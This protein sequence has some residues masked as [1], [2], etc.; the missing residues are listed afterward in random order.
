MIV[1]S[2]AIVLRARKQGETSKIVT[3]Y[4]R[5]FGKLNVIAK[6]AREI[7]SKFG[8]ALEM[9]AR[10]NVVFYKKDKPEGGLYLLSKADL[11]DSNG[12]I[13]KSL[14]TIE[15]ATAIVELILRAMHDEEEHPE[16]FDLLAG[17]LRQLS[18]NENPRIVQ[19]RFYME[20]VVTMGFGLGEQAERSLSPEARAWLRS[21]SRN[22]NTS[23]APGLEEELQRFF[24]DYFAEHLPGMNSHSMRSEKVFSEL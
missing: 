8:G 6:G 2:E 13:L 11:A 20:F 10:S 7:K 3:L 23:I 12:A 24:R 21:L 1:E 5:S 15:S 18:T 14:D 9:F 4:T 19:F 22:E 16:V 17:S